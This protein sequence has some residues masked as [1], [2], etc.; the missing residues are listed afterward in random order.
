MLIKF[1]RCP[2]T[3]SATK[4]LEKEF[5]LELKSLKQKVKH[6]KVMEK[7]SKRII[8]MS[9]DQREKAEGPFKEE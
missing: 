9:D 5:S 3:I 6:W 8:T 4:K 7:N 1:E 2:Q